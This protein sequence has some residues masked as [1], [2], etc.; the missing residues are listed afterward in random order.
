MVINLMD[1]IEVFATYNG[2]T[3]KYLVMA[4]TVQDLLNDPRYKEIKV[5]YF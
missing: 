4:V 5:F 1:E 3:K 2:I